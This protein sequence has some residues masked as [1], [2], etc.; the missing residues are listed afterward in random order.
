VIGLTLALT[1]PWN[2]TFWTA[3]MAQSRITASAV[4]VAAGVIAGAATWGAILCL[5]VNRLAKAFA[6]PLWEVLTNAATGALMLF[7]AIR[8][9]LSLS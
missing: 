9:L 5:G 2:I 3:V 1:S 4:V 7:F 6:H 8:T